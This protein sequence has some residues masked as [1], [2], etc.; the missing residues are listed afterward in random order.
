ME[1]FATK[2]KLMLVI[3]IGITVV[4]SLYWFFIH[5]RRRLFDN[6][7]FTFTIPHDQVK[8]IV[9]DNGMNVIIYKNSSQPKVLVQI[10]YDV[11]SFVED[12]GERGLAHLI[13]HMIFKG[14]EKY[15]ETDIDSIAR[16]YGATFNAFTSM[17]VT[18]YYFEV[19]KNNWQPFIGVLA[20]CMQHA[21]FEQEHLNSEVKAVV[22]ELKMGRDS[23]WRTVF[24]K[25]CQLLFPP[26]HPYHTPTIGFKE[27]LLSLDAEVLKR[28]YK[29]YYRPDKATLFVMGDVEFDDVETLTREHFE[30][31]TNGG[32]APTTFFPDPVSGLETNHTRIYEDVNQD[33]LA[34]YWLVPGLKAGS[35]HIVEA[36]EVLLGEG[37]SGRLYRLLVDD[38]KVAASVGVDAI[39]F[40]ENGIF[41]IMIEPLQGKKEQCEQ[42]VRQELDKIITKGIKSHELNRIAKYKGR[43]F[44]QKTQKFTD[45]VHDWIQSYF[46]TRDEMDIFKR[47][48]NYLKLDVAQVHG[49]IKT[50]LDP[51]LMN[52]I[53]VVSLP[54]SKRALKVD[55]NKKSDQMDQEILS[56]YSRQA[57]LEPP[58]AVA[59]YPDPKAVEFVFPK[60]QKVIELENGLK[61]LLAPDSRVPLISLECQFKESHFLGESKEG[62]NLNVMMEMLMEGSRGY[63]KKESVDF[64]E[65]YGAAYS[66]DVQGARLLC[67]NTDLVRLARRFFHILTQPTFPRKALEKIKHIFNDMYKRQQDS[68]KS[69]ALRLLKNHL[70]KGHPFEW[71]FQ[72]AKEL[73]SSATSTSLKELHS[74]YVNPANMVIS[75]VGDFNLDEMAASVEN[76]FGPWSRGENKE[77]PKTPAHFVPRVTVDHKMLRDQQILL[78][79]QPS[80]LTIHDPDVIP[81]KILNIICFSSLGSRIYQLRERTG[82]FYNAFGAFAAGAAK[83]QGY[84]FMGMIVNPQ[85]S[86]HAETELKKM[87]HQVMADGVTQEELAAAQLIYLKG[88]IDLMSSSSSIAAMLC[89]LDSLDLGFDYY[90]KVLERIQSISADELKQIAGKYLSPDNMARVRVGAL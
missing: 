50:H 10:A 6:A 13:E 57:P 53:E 31:I 19:N 46:A 32:D 39:Q 86:S 38:Q 68:P 8:K 72:Q 66:F 45:F 69:M 30:S 84:D 87:L 22:Q 63:S 75:I 16:K 12:S 7:R 49:Y 14:T 23:Y 25:T 2:I 90:D 44:F 33:I 78:L 43:M 80:P 62:I 65:G 64:F 34:F 42:L 82:L 35:K 41:L 79:G 52:R 9:L 89:S 1:L 59:G 4:I 56:K 15:S 21:R 73:I 83:H 76:I 5:N 17:D 88:L 74:Q 29:K 67:L 61:V 60:P 81:L 51:F 48:E 3:F 70:Y 58:K 24:Q 18:S 20:E 37:Q 47:V 85:N 54:E 27:D 36:V 40:M 28:F 11:G 55:L 26:H 71:T 77:I